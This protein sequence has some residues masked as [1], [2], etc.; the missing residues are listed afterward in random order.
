M[1]KG[2]PHSEEEKADMPVFI[3]AVEL[4]ERQNNQ[5]E[6]GSAKE[7]DIKDVKEKWP[8]RLSEAEP[9]DYAGGN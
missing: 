7:E 3:Q 1:E 8:M 5:V 9:S 2:K 4:N 6:A